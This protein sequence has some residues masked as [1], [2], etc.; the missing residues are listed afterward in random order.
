[1]VATFGRLRNKIAKDTVMGRLERAGFSGHGAG[2]LEAGGRDADQAI[3]EHLSM[4]YACM[5]EGK[6]GR[7]PMVVTAECLGL[8]AETT[9]EQIHTSVTEAF[10]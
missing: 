5:V 6:V 2:I 4:L 10:Q 8:L 1:V 3:C 7:I 9:A